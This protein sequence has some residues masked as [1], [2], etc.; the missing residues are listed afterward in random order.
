MEHAQVGIYTGI[1]AIVILVIAIISIV[2][3]RSSSSNNSSSKAQAVA[4]ALNLRSIVFVEGLIISYY[5]KCIECL[6]MN[7]SLPSSPAAL[8]L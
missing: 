5:L 6:T 4:A 7:S 2:V 3:V 8:P 1:F